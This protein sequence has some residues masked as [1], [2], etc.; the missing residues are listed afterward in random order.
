MAKSN[1]IM[2]Y[3]IENKGNFS[4][5]ALIRPEKLF[6]KVE[7]C[8]QALVVFNYLDWN[9]LLA[10]LTIVPGSQKNFRFFSLQTINTP[11]NQNFTFAGPA[12]SA[13]IT[14]MVLEIL[15]AF[16][17]RQ[18]I[19]IGSCGSLTDS[20]R[21][22]QL[23]VPEGVI[24]DEG[25]SVH[26]PLPGKKLRPAVRLLNKIK[27]CCEKNKENW[28]GGI[29]WTTDALFRETPQKIINAKQ[30]RAIAVE[31]EV[32][33][34]LKVGN[35]YR[36][37]VAAVL[38]VSDELFSFRWNPGYTTPEYKHAIFRAQ[39]IALKVLSEFNDGSQNPGNNLT[40]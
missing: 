28:V 16:G 38:A 15:I 23:V 2:E 20:L 29:I 13:P 40:Q 34:F 1:R 21:I 6:K 17:A 22:G 7:V 37:E 25:T 26:Y 19:G 10:R 30:K 3:C 31:M 36:V 4:S 32:S 9:S 11:D 5:T 27:S 18:I 35:F 39:D 12:M 24:A 14:A 33:A 8:P